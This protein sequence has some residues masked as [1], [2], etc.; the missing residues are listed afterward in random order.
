V[1]GGNFLHSAAVL[2]Q[3]QVHQIEQRTRV[4]RAYRFPHFK[5]LHWCVSRVVE[6]RKLHARAACG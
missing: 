6:L 1:F 2:R 5:E 3:L 4:G